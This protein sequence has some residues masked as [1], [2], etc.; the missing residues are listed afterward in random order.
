M[1]LQCKN[2]SESSGYKIE[3][4]VFTLCLLRCRVCANFATETTR[5][6]AAVAREVH[7]LKVAGSI[8]A[9]ATKT[10]FCDAG[11]GRAGTV[12]PGAPEAYFS[13]E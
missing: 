6:R 1:F 10:L 7:S 5:S 4:K 11:R 8:P 9:S 13:N 3:C 2:A 12:G